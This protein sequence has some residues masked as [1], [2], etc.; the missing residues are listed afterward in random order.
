MALFHYFSETKLAKADL[1]LPAGKFKNKRSNTYFVGTGVMGGM[2]QDDHVPFQTKG[3][4]HIF[5]L[6]KCHETW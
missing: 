4:V 3:K 1:L 6:A 2:I 5:L